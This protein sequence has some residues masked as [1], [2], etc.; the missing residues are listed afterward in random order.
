M[1]NIL[2]NRYISSVR[3]D[4]INIP[5]T[6]LL[7][8]DGGTVQNALQVFLKIAAAVAMLVIAVGALKYV[9]SRGD[10][11]SIKNAKETIIYAAVGLVVTMSAYGIVTFVVSRV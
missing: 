11:N 2:I 5:H 4:Q 9:L 7:S 8:G 10:P 6:P 1:K 3:E